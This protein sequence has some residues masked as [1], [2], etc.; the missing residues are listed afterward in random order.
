MPVVYIPPLGIPDEFEITHKVNSPPI[1]IVR[2]RARGEFDKS[3][4]LKPLASIAGHKS[5]I[6][7]HT[8]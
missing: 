6:A 7:P 5:A 3:P 4:S 8:T 2:C 1:S